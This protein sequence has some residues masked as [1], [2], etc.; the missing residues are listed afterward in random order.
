MQSIYSQN[1]DEL[2]FWSLTACRGGDTLVVAK[3]A[4]LDRSLRDATDIVE[5]LMAMTE[6]SRKFGRAR[7]NRAASTNRVIHMFAC[8][9][10]TGTLLPA[11]PASAHRTASTSATRTTLNHSNMSAS[12]F[13]IC[14]S[15][16]PPR[17]PQPRHSLPQPHSLLFSIHSSF[18]FLFLPAPPPPL[19][20]PTSVKMQRSLGEVGKRALLGGGG[21]AGKK[22]DKPFHY[23]FPPREV[24]TEPP[25][26]EM[27]TCECRV[28][29]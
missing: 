8:L 20:F 24:V 5:E 29:I 2:A 6:P 11:S 23:L 3:L 12:R 9:G 19:Y 13:V 26:S 10:V 25:L 7:P 21:G 28:R 1:A 15:A 14:I 16:P 27:L 4:R 17:P 22:R 18:L